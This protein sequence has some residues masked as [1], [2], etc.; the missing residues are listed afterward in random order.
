MS[1]ES[2]HIVEGGTSIGPFD[3]DQM[4]GRIRDGRLGPDTLVWHDG[5]P[6]WEAASI[7]FDF[8]GTAAPPLPTAHA[9]SGGQAYGSPAGQGG[10][11]G[12]DGLYVG[13]PSRSF[14]EAIRV[15]FSKFVTF[16]G[17]AS[18]SEYWWF[19]LFTFIGSFLLG[20]LDA[21]LF[22]S[23]S[24]PLGTL[25]GLAVLLPSISAAVRRLHDTD[26]SGWWIG[27]F[28]I[29]LLVFVI[30]LGGALAATAPAMS[31]DAALEMMMGFGM[32]GLVLM[33]ALLIYSI[34]MLVFLCTRGTPG[35]N[36]FG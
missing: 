11:I 4:I 2:W 21:V 16:R 1:G 22:G 35:P 8:A 26:R 19:T 12:P 20:L 25:F 23:D 14:G 32:L 31:D 36:R 28:Y 9:P 6:N 24:G 5:L 13:A 29:A 3:T 18:R 17:R 33:V 27:G 34:L 7:H 30:L 10:H 15:C